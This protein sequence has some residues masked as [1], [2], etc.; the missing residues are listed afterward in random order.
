VNHVLDPDDADASGVDG[1]DGLDQFMTFG[2]GQAAGDF[3]EQQ[4]AWPGGERAR[5]LQ[6]FAVEQRQASG[7]TVGLRL[8][9][10]QSSVRPQC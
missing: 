6:P 8:Q 7:A 3:V 5:Q 4:R 10:G 9:S 2:L 1:S